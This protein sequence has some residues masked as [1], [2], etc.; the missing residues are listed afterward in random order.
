MTDIISD[1]VLGDL[2]VNRSTKYRNV[3]IRIDSRGDFVVSAPKRMPMIAIKGVVRASRGQLMKFKASNSPEFKIYDGMPVGKKHKLNIT[4]ASKTTVRKAG[5]QIIILIASTDS[6]ESQAVIRLA[7]NTIIDTLRVE[8]KEY[9]PLRV[10]HFASLGQFEYGKLKYTHATSRWGS[11]SSN[12]TIS[13]NIALMNLPFELIDYVIVHELCHTVHMNHS[14]EFWAL[15][16]TLD[17]SYLKHKSELKK[18]TPV[19]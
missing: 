1:S 11:R 10:K 15:V 19:I 13:L 18:Y 2:K 7:K 12:G 16:G 3:K 14:K 4:R 17:A 6:P 5:N 9:I 8:A